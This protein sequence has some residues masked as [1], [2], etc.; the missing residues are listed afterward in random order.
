MNFNDFALQRNMI[1]DDFP[2]L[3][4]YQFYSYFFRQ[5]DAKMDPK[6]DQIE[7]KNNPD[8][9]FLRFWG[10][11]GGGVF[12]MF[13]G[14]GKNQPKTRKIRHVGSKRASRR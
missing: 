11:L 14:T 6:S 7:T 5:K 8:A 1:F 2:D 4:R 9:G 3:F 10:V 12:S 13:F